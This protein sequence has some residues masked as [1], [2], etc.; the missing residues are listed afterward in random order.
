MYARGVC[1]SALRL[2]ITSSVIWT[3]Y[4]WL[5]KFYSFYVVAVSLSM[6]GV[7][8]KLKH[9]IE[10]KIVRLSYRF[11]NHYFTFT[12]SCLKQMYISI[13]KEQFSFRGGCGTH[14]Q[15]SKEELAWAKDTALGY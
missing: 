8:L 5:N 3:P 6:I 9:I 7:T 11:T 10:T 2:L 4:D 1:V 15:A 12:Y 13:K 14:I